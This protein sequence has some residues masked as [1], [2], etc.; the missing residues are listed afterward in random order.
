MMRLMLM[1]KEKKGKISYCSYIRQIL[2]VL[3]YER[4]A[5][6]CRRPP[7]WS[8]EEGKGQKVHDI[9]VVVRPE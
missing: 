6:S 2:R 7:Y 9:R 1:L 3:Q 8:D 5:L 4:P